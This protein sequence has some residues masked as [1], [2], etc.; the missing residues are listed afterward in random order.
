M[1]NQKL[2]DLDGLDEY[3]EK[4]VIVKTDGYG[5]V[6][7]YGTFFS[8][9]FMSLS[10]WIGGL[11]ILIGLYY[12]PD[13]RFEILGRHSKNRPLRLV[14]YV[15]IGIIQAFVLGTVLKVALGF[16]VTNLLLFYGSCI[17][18]SLA[19][20]SI[21]MFLFFNLGDVGK[22]IAIVWLVVQLAACGG[23]FP[24][25]VEP[26][27]FRIISPFMPMTYS[28]ELLRESFVSIEHSLLIKDVIVL[29]C[30][31]IGCSALVFG[32]GYIKTK[33]QGKK[34]KK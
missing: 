7:D 34:K 33:K 13:N 29:T 16:E 3:V 26:N 21:M 19:F 12:D 10:F 4:P 23:T 15:L 2:D 5:D 6:N 24:L 27:F 18:I 32:F 14:Y 1:K 28:V 11:L 30:I 31:L 22:F 17:L 25:E 9:F 8:P 20:L